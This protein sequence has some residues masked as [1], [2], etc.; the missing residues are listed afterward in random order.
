MINIEKKETLSSARTNRAFTLIELLVVISII[1]VLMAIMMPALNKARFQAQKSICGNNLKQVTVA[2]AGYQADNKGKMAP[3]VNGHNWGRPETG[4][5]YSYNWSVA[6]VY[7]NYHI[8]QAPLG[9]AGGKTSSYLG[10]YVDGAKVFFCPLNK[11]PDQNIIT[12]NYMNPQ[13][14]YANF[15]TGSYFF[16]WNYYGFSQKAGTSL[17][18]A[19]QGESFEPCGSNAGSNTLVIT[20][21]SYYYGPKQEWRTSHPFANGSRSESYYV[22]NSQNADSIPRLRIGLNAGYNDGHVSSYGMDEIGKY[23][24]SGTVQLLLTNKF[25]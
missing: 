14:I 16:L 20:D 7:L 12:E 13:G 15:F 21:V 11:T 17:Y 22:Y 9:L 5:V 8:N 25:K 24:D 3:S 19:N 6:P 1:A 18:R 4:N 23:S 10:S 2:L